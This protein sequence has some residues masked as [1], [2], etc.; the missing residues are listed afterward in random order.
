MKSIYWALF[1]FSVLFISC[2]KNDDN[3]DNP[4]ANTR[5][6]FKL[7]TILYNSKYSSG[8]YRDTTEIIIDSANNK[9]IFREIEGNL[10]NL[11]TS[12]AVFSYNSQN[13]LV[14]YEKTDTYD[15]LYISRMEFVRDADGK[16]TKVLSGYGH[17]LKP[18][19][20]GSVNY[21]K[22]GDTTFITYIDSTRKHPQG[23]T[24]AQDYY[25]IG[26]V[27]DKVVY[28]KRYSMSTLAKL[29]STTYRY[30][31]DAAG[32]VITES[33]QYRNNTPTV[34]TY[35][36]GSE[37]PKELQKFLSQWAGDLLWFRRSKLFSFSEKLPTVNAVAGNV[38]V[39][40]KQ[41]S[42]ITESY[43]NTFDASGNLGVVTWQ[44]L[45]GSSPTT[46]TEKY[47]Y[48]P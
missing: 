4:P 40:K 31:Y 41:G 17:G 47:I 44:D 30:E 16:V 21:D 8:G 46:F 10:S 14:L 45:S 15:Y 33:S 37:S 39:S 32:N 43:T 20:E 26:Q 3:N 42:T 11:D 12:L 22:R 1:V 27:S 48:R 34:Y 5:E 28:Y 38:L 18:T 35:Q 13:Q 23:Y 29:D 24:D 7:K 6:W 9:I 36:R 19:S 25:T 2:N